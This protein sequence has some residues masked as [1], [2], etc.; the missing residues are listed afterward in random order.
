MK[1]LL[2]RLLAPSFGSKRFRRFYEV[3]KNISLLGL[4]YRDTNIKTNGEQFYIERI[5]RYYYNL[6]GPLVIF[7]VGANVGNYSSFINDSIHLPR[8]IY[9]FEPFSK[10]FAQLRKLSNSIE[11]FYPFQLGFSNIQEKQTF[12]SS[13]AYSEVGSLYNKDFSQLGF[14][15]DMSEEVSFDTI[16]NFCS[17]RS[18]SK[19]HFLKID[20]EG[21]DF[22]V[23]QGANKMLSNNSIDFIQ[24]EFGAANYLSKTYLYDFFQL[25]SRDY[26]ICKLLKNGFM[27]IV[28]YNTD[29][30][31]HVLSNYVA[32]NRK[33]GFTIR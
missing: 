11:D 14:S 4:N 2:F 6:D 7:D 3:L 10:V 13:S 19:I 24:F 33:L 8:K 18:I 25:L 27:E 1:K 31:I 29:I 26:I 28:E 5:A 23:L 17:N 21:H 30:E 15:L 32:I 16:D 12:L 22:F 9:A 20:V